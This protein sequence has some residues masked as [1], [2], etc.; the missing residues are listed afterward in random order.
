MNE[1]LAADIAGFKA[2][3]EAIAKNTRALNAEPDPMMTFNFLESRRPFSIPIALLGTLEGAR[4]RA[5]HLAE[6]AP[7]HS[8][9]CA[10]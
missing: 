3:G 1:Q 10:V 6:E 7:G 5:E 9:R 4:L 2:Q 8:I